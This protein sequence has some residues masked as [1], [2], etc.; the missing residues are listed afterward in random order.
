MKPE[1]DEQFDFA[2]SDKL[3]SDLKSLFEPGT[4]VPS[5]ID[6][7]VMDTASRELLGRPQRR[8]YIC[9]PAYAA[10]AAAVIVIALLVSDFAKKTLP[11]QMSGP[12]A[13]KMDMNADGVVDILDA[14][15][16]AKQIDSDAANMQWDVNADGV[17]DRQ[18]V[19]QVAA[20]AVRLNQE[21][22]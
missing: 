6:R 12:V 4:S 7:A 17:V 20:V 5:Q 14:F 15:K 9:W 22:L 19:D 2:V 18:D 16:L 8:R 1:N 13:M 3:S 11:Q 10:A 21:V